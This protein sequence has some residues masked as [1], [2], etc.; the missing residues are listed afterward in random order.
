[1]IF[2]KKYKNRMI[3]ALIAIILI[4]II[5]ITSSERIKI[6]AIERFVGNVFSP[7]QKV[8]FSV[9]RN[10]SD[11]FTSIKD[12]FS[13]KEENEQLKLKILELED[14]IRKYEDIIGRSEYLINEKKLLENTSY[15]LIAAQVTG[16]EP[17]NWFNRFTIDKGLKDGIR[18]GDTVIQAV[19]VD[20]EIVQEG[21]VGRIIDVGDNWAKVISIIDESNNISFKVIRTQDGGILSGNIDGNLSGYLFDSKADIMKGD[22]LFSSGLGG[23]YVDN[24]YIGEITNVIKEDEDLAKKIE[25]EPAVD[26]KKI[27][28]VFVITNRR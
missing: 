18:K 3:V 2:F 6:T 4:V 24:L 8:V 11:F 23:I 28:K 26:F 9:G 19:K 17:G 5:G 20:G 16:K 7:V 15:N 14:T 21:V 1:M 13:L 12:L 25:V 22:K 27:Y 10:I